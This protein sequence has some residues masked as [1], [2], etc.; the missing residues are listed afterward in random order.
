MLVPFQ[1]V[2]LQY[3][4]LN[5]HTFKIIFSDLYMI[6]VVS[7]DVFHAEILDVPIE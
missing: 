3:F 6:P 5:F 7:T 4:Q 2:L 1:I